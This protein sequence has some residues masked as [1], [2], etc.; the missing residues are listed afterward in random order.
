M[1]E[2]PWLHF[3]A[4][5]DVQKALDV[6]AQPVEKVLKALSY[7]LDFSG[8]GKQSQNGTLTDQKLIANLILSEWNVRRP[9][10]LVEGVKCL[11]AA[12]SSAQRVPLRSQTSA[13]NM[14]CAFVENK[15]IRV[16]ENAHEICR[17]VAQDL[18]ILYA[19]TFP[20]NAGDVHRVLWRTQRSA[21][22]ASRR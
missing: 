19:L 1:K 18:N 9:H 13:A 3:V 14:D 4:Q 17:K 7:L 2:L 20:S 6:T 5:R 22:G 21:T 16:A 11:W 15:P 12:P 10:A 8:L